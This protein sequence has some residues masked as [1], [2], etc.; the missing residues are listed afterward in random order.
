M[1][2]ARKQDKQKILSIVK[3][4]DI[5]AFVSIAKVSGVFGK[6]FDEVKL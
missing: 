1:V 5:N 3:D 2:I 6:N 4:T